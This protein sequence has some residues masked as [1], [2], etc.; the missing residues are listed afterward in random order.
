MKLVGRIGED[1]CV[2]KK[3]TFVSASIRLK[4]EASVLHAGEAP[5]RT[6]SRAPAIPQSRD[7]RT[8]SNPYPVV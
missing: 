3:Q 7:A 4:S 5:R 6:H 2:L 1:C 8:Q